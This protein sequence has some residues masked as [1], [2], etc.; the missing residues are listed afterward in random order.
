[1]NRERLPVCRIVWGLLCLL[2][3]LAAQVTAEEAKSPGIQFVQICDTQLGFGEKGYEQD[4]ESFRQAVRQINAMKPAFVVICGDLVHKPEPQAFADFKEVMA[5]LEVPCRCA[6]GNHDL[7]HPPTA[8]SLAKYREAIGKDYYSFK[9]QGITFV[10]VNTEFWKA[11]VEGETAAH[12]RWFEETLRQAKAD[13]SPVI[14]AGHH[15]LFLKKADEKEEYF[16]I[17]PEKRAEILRLFKENGVVA[18]LSGHTHRLVENEYEGIQF[19]SGEA[20][21]KNFDKR[22]F[23][24][25]VWEVDEAGKVS[26]RFVALEE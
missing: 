19:L 24:F 22:P 5:E 12:D 16:N 10:V 2:Q 4:V 20:T 17:P 7:G 25:R 18:M 1:M 26:H 15:P 8:A 14:V 13:S 21:S 3:P 9:H 6:A 11:P 23:G